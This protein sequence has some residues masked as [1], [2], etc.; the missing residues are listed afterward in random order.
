MGMTTRA[1]DW[2]VAALNQVGAAAKAEG[3][4]WVSFRSQ[5]AGV[6]E[7]FLFTGMGT[8]K[9]PSMN[10]FTVPDYDAS[11][12]QYS[13][14]TCNVSFSLQDLNLA[15]GRL[16]R[17]EGSP[18]NGYGLLYLS[19][20]SFSQVMFEGQ[21]CLSWLAKESTGSSMRAVGIWRSLTLAGLNSCDV[22]KAG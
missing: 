22:S 21:S 16:T 1:N 3:L 14:L 19:A 18:M 13:S 17:V 11:K 7:M 5:Q 4:C 8:G 15:I 2:E 6:C 12:L 20:L 9:P 10:G